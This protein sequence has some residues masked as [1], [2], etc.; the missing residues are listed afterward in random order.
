MTMPEA[1]SALA[2]ARDATL[3]DDAVVERVR[4]GETGLYEVLMRRHNTRVYRAV[5]S[6][7]RDEG[8]VEDVMQQAYLAAFSKL[9]QFSGAARFSTWLISIALNEAHTRL[10]RRARLAAVT[11]VP[12]GRTSSDDESPEGEVDMRE[13]VAL[14]ERELDALPEAYRTV[15]MLRVVEEL[16]TDDT[17]AILGVSSDVVKTRLHRARAMLRDA[18]ERVLDGAAR[19]A[20]PFHAPRCDRVVAGVLAALPA[21]A[22]DPTS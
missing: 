20:F 9:D 16:D 10:R 12:D 5:R 18:F 2:L 4:H 17:A 14:V 13:R 8:E 11:A 15:L 6:V 7:L 19:D 22:E 1:S 21:G 3:T